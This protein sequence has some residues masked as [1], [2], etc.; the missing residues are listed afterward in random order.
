MEAGVKY[1]LISHNNQV[2]LGKVATPNDCIQEEVTRGGT[3]V[4]WHVQTSRSP[5]MQP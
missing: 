4:G 1:I 2:L 3:T 5:L